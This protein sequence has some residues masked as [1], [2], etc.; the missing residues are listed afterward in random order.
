MAEN[1]KFK[2]IVE[3]AKSN[4]GAK[5]RP[6]LTPTKNRVVTTS[7]SAETDSKNKILATQAAYNTLNEGKEKGLSKSSKAVIATSLTLAVATAVAVPL[8][9]HL[10][11]T[12]N[13]FDITI[14][15][16]F[17]TESQ[18]NQSV[19][20]KPGTLISEL[21][22][23]QREGFVFKGW[24]KDAACTIPYESNYVIQ[25]DDMVY[26][27]LEVEVVDISLNVYINGQLTTINTQSGKTIDEALQE[28]NIDVENINIPG[29]HL[30]G[31]FKDEYGEKMYPNGY[32]L[33]KS[34]TAIY[35]LYEINTY[36]FAFPQEREGYYIQDT[37][38]ELITS[39]P[40]VTY[41]QDFS[42]KLRI[43]DGYFDNGLVV[44]ANGE[45]LTPVNETYTFTSI[46]SNFN[47]Q[48]R[49]IKKIEDA[50][51]TVVVNGVSTKY[52]ASSQMTLREFFT[53]SG[54]N[55]T[56]ENTSGIFTNSDL[57]ESVTFDTTIDKDATYYIYTATLEKLAFT[58]L[59]LTEEEAEMFGVTSAYSVSAVDYNITGDVVIPAYYN[60]KP[61]T[62]I[63][64][65]AFCNIE[66][67]D[68]D[69]GFPILLNISSIVLPN[70]LTTI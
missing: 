45:I 7:K 23:I 25:E 53:Q 58:E 66:S 16:R 4:K 46:G 39:N 14:T 34:D 1:Q 65:S 22:P 42:F 18:E 37:A 54:L 10:I 30:A 33:K 52:N 13:P 31:I 8:S 56:E 41:G 70:T 48:V 40:R 57:T 28:N 68:P 44:T 12:N 69:T 29:Y 61:V 36:I 2:D 35:A 55:Y 19:S 27:L 51:F 38:G 43:A 15:S 17:D 24:Y 26:A 50:D 21:T 6:S 64:E 63:G 5:A 67:E 47:I 62:M 60:G 49:G 59:E 20:V 11:N 9:I 3:K 32:I